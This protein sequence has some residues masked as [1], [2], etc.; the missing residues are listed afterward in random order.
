MLGV[1]LDPSSISFTENGPVN[2]TESLYVWLVLLTNLLW[3]PNS[4]L[5]AVDTSGLP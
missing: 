4:C 1:S 3:D 2:Q 5:E